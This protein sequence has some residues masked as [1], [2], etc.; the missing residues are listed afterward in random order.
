MTLKPSV[1]SV[2]SLRVDYEDVLAVCDIS[3]EIRPG[4]IYGLVGP[5]GA[6]KTSTLKA[7]ANL[8]EPTYGE[9]TIAGF[10][11]ET[12]RQ[13]ALA[14]IGFAADFPPVYENLK[15][16]EYMEI[17][18]AAY[19]IPA[20]HRLDKC[21]HWICRLQLEDK[22]DAVIRTLSR[23]M[24]QRL[25]IAMTLMHDPQIVL[26]DEPASGLDPAARLLLRN[27][28]KDVAAGGAG[29]IIS[30]HILTELS[31]LCTCVGIME[32]GRLVVSGSL[33]DIRKQ[34]GMKNEMVIEFSV[35]NNELK[36]RLLEILQASP[37]ITDPREISPGK[38]RALTNADDSQA[39][40]I[41]RQLIDSALPVCRFHVKA[42]NVEDIFFKIGAMSSS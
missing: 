31:D 30:S 17:F 27:L 5:N 42:A 4:E 39:A 13:E 29:V 18:A 35:T 36:N 8:L 3:L 25:V 10:D 41:L 37:L 11:L 33:E 15:V 19:H 38:F 9:I 23:G 22:K 28:I 7:L 26:L 6:G 14:R 2:R 21:H 34:A 32:K 40:G 16:W 12:E 24:R 20:E 1:I